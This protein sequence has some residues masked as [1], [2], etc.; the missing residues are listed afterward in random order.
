MKKWNKK[1]KSYESLFKRIKP[2]CLYVLFKIE[3]EDLFRISNK[4][5]FEMS[6]FQNIHISTILV[7]QISNSACMSFRVGLLQI[8]KNLNINMELRVDKNIFFLSISEV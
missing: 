6:S 7:N 4:I 1:N 3:N 5:L 8:K 2:E